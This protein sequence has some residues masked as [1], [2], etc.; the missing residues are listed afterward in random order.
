[1][2]FQPSEDVDRLTSH[3][4]WGL[5]K[6][7]L[8]G[9]FTSE[10]VGLIRRMKGNAPGDGTVMRPTPVGVELFLWAHGK[11]DLALRALL[12]RNVV[13]SSIASVILPS[14][15]SIDGN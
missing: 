7:Q 11:R 13:H 4:L 10:K 5:A 8:I 2:D 1:M 9:Y 3:I 14:G 12:D 6:E 15:D